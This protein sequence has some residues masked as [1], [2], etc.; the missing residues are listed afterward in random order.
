[1][2]AHPLHLYN[3][4]IQLTGGNKAK[5]KNN[6]LQKNVLEMKIFSRYI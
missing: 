3:S 6:S 1:M 2:A 5:K 4:I